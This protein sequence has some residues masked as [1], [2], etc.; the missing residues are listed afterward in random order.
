MEYS[1]I[2][3]T[4]EGMRRDNEDRIKYFDVVYDKFM[5]K[6]KDRNK[7]TPEE[8]HEI[9]R[10]IGKQFPDV[11]WYVIE[12]IISRHGWGLWYEGDGDMWEM[13]GSMKDWFYK[14]N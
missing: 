11:A 13:M 4:P 7:L 5:E 12:A 9:N 2:D 6:V 1:V 10:E 14:K 8:Y 3:T